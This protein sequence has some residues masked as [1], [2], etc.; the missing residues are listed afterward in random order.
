MLILVNN[1]ILVVKRVA[2]CADVLKFVTRSYRVTSLRTSARNEAFKRHERKQSDGS[3][4]KA[5]LV[6]SYQLRRPISIQI[7]PS[8]SVERKEIRE[9]DLVSKETVCYVGGKM[10]H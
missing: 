1:R 8:A 6:P 7:M 10:K 5:F 4:R 9:G 3:E 2:S